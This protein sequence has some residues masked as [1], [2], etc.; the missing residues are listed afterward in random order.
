MR[1]LEATSGPAAEI[2]GVHHEIQAKV[3]AAPRGL[4]AKD[5]CGQF[6]T[7]SKPATVPTPAKAIQGVSAK[8]QGTTQKELQMPIFLLE[9]LKIGTW[10]CLIRP[11]SRL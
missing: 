5:G 6:G 8:G 2:G 7:A 4:G 11:H 3:S 10:I 9:S 1:F